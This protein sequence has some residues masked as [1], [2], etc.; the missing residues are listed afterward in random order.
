M[1]YRLI[2]LTEQQRAIVGLAREFAAAEIAPHAARWDREACFDRG[3]AEN[4]QRIEPALAARPWRRIEH[5]F[6]GWPESPAPIA[7]EAA[8]KGLRIVLPGRIR[9]GKGEALLAALLPKLP[10]DI[11]YR[12]LGRHLVLHDTRANMILDRIPCAVPGHSRVGCHR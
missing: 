7:P 9:G 12:F 11:E 4:L 2:P 10:D 5:G 8:R 1:P 3:V 6:A